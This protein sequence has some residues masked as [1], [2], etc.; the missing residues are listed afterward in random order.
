M[1]AGPARPA[2]HGGTGQPAAGSGSVVTGAAV[3]VVVV[4]DHPLFRQGIGA[5]IR[6]SPETELAA[7][8]ASGEEAVGLCAQLDPG[9]VGI[10]VHMAGM[11]GGEATRQILRA[12]PGTAIVML[13]MMDEDDSVFAAMRAGARGYG[14]KGAQPAEILRAVVAV[15]SGQAIFGRDV[16]ERMAGYFAEA[17]QAG[18]AR[19]F[20]QLTAREREIL[21]LMAAGAGNGAIAARLG[22][23]EKTIRNNVSAIFVKLGVADRAAA[24]ARARDAGIRPRP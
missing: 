2:R 1:R 5:L 7:E 8:G 12:A 6:D 13:T 9:G 3:R 15:A 23:T 21:E 20:G 24:V 4:D 17:G 16:A 14:L 22:L 11:G 19:P 18:A 10:D